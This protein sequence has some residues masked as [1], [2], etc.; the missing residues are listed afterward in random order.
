MTV[1]PAAPRDTQEVHA[2]GQHLVVAQ[3][4]RDV[5]AGLAADLD[6]GAAAALDSHAVN[7][8]AHAFTPNPA[9]ARYGGPVVPAAQ[10]LGEDGGAS[11]ATAPAR[12]PED[13]GPR[14]QPASPSP[15]APAE[16]LVGKGKSKWRDGSFEW[17]K[18]GVLLGGGCEALVDDRLAHKN[19]LYIVADTSKGDIKQVRD[20]FATLQGWLASVLIPSGVNL[21]L[22]DLVSYRDQGLLNKFVSN[23]SKPSR[24]ALK[25]LLPHSKIKGKNEEE[26]LDKLQ[27]YVGFLRAAAKEKKGIAIRAVGGMNEYDI[28][29]DKT[30]QGQKPVFLGGA[31]NADE[32]SRFLG[33]AE[34]VPD[35]QGDLDLEIDGVQRVG[36]DSYVFGSQAPSYEK[37]AAP[38]AAKADVTAPGRPETPKASVEQAKARQPTTLVLDDLNFEEGTGFLQGGTLKEFLDRQ[39]R[40]S[41]GVFIS[42]VGFW[43]G[44]RAGQVDKMADELAALI[45]RADGVKVLYTDITNDQSLLDWLVHSDKFN[46]AKLHQLLVSIYIPD[47]T[48]IKLRAYVRLLRTV[49]NQ[50]NIEVRRLAD[51]KPS[52]DPYIILGH[53]GSA[54]D[55]LPKFVP[56]SARKDLGPT[57]VKLVSKPGDPPE[58]LIAVGS[59]KTDATTPSKTAPSAGAVAPPK[60]ATPPKP[61]LRQTPPRSWSAAPPRSAPTAKPP[62]P[63]DDK[64]P[65]DKPDI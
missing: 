16:T 18:E 11:T 47:V 51:R 4:K 17:S 42:D 28:K 59:A 14:A 5:A 32:T 54:V 36:P 46:E 29:A 39:L 20:M 62:E 25:E 21:I 9:G 35:L 1:A 27:A 30:L 43:N 55:K 44:A 13:N 38:P 34:F 57:G 50:N 31:A 33:L 26:S 52:N 53:R 23:E 41:G 7:H 22:A 19:G 8:N 24:A 6:P 56:D 64:K 12:P 45:T 61:A 3:G 10:F 2:D 15:Q 58:V 65:A 40:A 48:E 60:T 63:A 37:I 49:W